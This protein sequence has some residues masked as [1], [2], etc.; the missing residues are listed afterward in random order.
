MVN[1]FLMSFFSKYLEYVFT[2]QLENQ[3]D[4]VA[5]GK[6]DSL[7]LLRDFWKP[8]IKVIEEVSLLQS[9]VIMKTIENLLQKLIHNPDGEKSCSSCKKGFLH[10][11]QGK[12]GAF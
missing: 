3:L 11:K 10:L 4:E 1:A 5:N 2:A 12:R 8:F 9:N 6:K 7:L